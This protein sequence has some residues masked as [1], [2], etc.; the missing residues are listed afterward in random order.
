[1]DVVFNVGDAVV[2]VADVDGR[3]DGGELAMAA[4]SMWVACILGVTRFPVADAIVVVVVVACTCTFVQ[5]SIKGGAYV[6]AGIFVPF[7]YSI[8]VIGI[9]GVPF[10]GRATINVCGGAGICG[11]LRLC[12]LS[13][14]CWYALL[15]QGV[16]GVFIVVFVV[17][18]I[19]IRG[20]KSGASGGA[21]RED[22]VAG[23]V[24][25]REVAIVAGSAEL[26]GVFIVG[27]VVDS[28]GKGEGNWARQISRRGG[29]P[30]HHPDSKGKGIVNP[31]LRVVVF[32]VVF[33][34][35]LMP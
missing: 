28:D 18:G 35:G 21:G 11:R 12:S 31:I 24:S 29:Y 9:G 33:Q 30:A 4:E 25:H 7:F 32:V 16:S 8:I 2:A 14:N 27:G 1:V 17:V 23:T 22:V 6:A 10:G 15:L 5:V 26:S 34:S 3:V 20:E 13:C 19:G